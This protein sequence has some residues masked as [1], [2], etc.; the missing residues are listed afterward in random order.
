MNKPR[1]AISFSGGRTSAVMA[2]L[3]HEQLGET[4]ELVTTFANTS[5]EDNRTLDF[6]HQCDE[7]FGWNVVWLEAVIH[8]EHGKGTTHRVV[9]YETACR[10]GS[11]FE[12]Y[13][14]KYGI[15]N[16]GNPACTTR[17]KENALDSYRASLGWKKG[18]YDTA[19]GIRAD[20]V[21]RMSAKALEKRFIYPLIKA[22]WTKEMVIREVRTWPFDLQIKEHEG[23][24]VDCWKKS[25]RKLATLSIE[26]PEIFDWTRRME[27]RYAFFKVTDATRSPDGCRR[28][29]R[30]H[31]TVSDIFAEGEKPGF[32]PFSDKY[33][34]DYADPLDL[35]GGCGES[36]EIGTD[37]ADY[38]EA[39]I[40]TQEDWV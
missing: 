30:G 6:V 31:R 34:V 28:F 5:R 22:G 1:I 8:P 35:A 7:H 36:C 32:T 24:C 23:N 20:E 18:T 29:F 26:R 14:A 33:S 19:I 4:H 16:M 9:T 11:V 13:I 3:L 38:E 39:I 2:K 10:D 27:S 25:F 40:R 15:P 17:L 21:D 37:T 12:S